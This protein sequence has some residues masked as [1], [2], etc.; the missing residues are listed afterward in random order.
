M[1]S[2]SPIAHNPNSVPTAG[3]GETDVHTSLGY[4]LQGEL[5][6]GKR[7]SVGSLVDVYRGV[8]IKPESGA[9]EVAIK[10]LRAFAPLG[11]E[12]PSDRRQALHQAALGLQHL[13]SRD[14][15]VV[16]GNICPENV[17]INDF[18]AAV[19]SDFDLSRA[20]EEKTG[21]TTT[22]AGG[23]A[24]RYL[25]P[26]AFTA[27]WPSS[28]TFPTDI[29]AF[30][31][32]I[33]TAMSGRPPHHHILGVGRYLLA[34]MQGAIPTPA[35]HPGLPGSDSLWNLM[36]T[37]WANGP[38]DRPSID[39]VVNFL[40]RE[41]SEDA[42]GQPSSPVTLRV[43]LLTVDSAVDEAGS[44]NDVAESDLQLVT[45]LPGELAPEKDP[46]LE[47]TRQGG[48]A[49]VVRGRWTRPDGVTVAVAI[50]YLRTVVMQKTRTPKERVLRVNKRVDR[51]A[52]V[53]RRLRSPYILEFYGFRSGDQPC[54]V[55]PWCNNGT[56]NEYLQAHP[57][58]T[59]VDKLNLL[60]QAGKGLQYLHH[61]LPPISHGDIKPSNI[62]IDDSNCPRLCDFGLSRFL[63]EINPEL[64]T[65]FL[66]QG[67]KGYQSPELVRDGVQDLPG[68]VYAFGCLILEVMSGHAPFYKLKPG[69]AIL[70]TTAGSTPEPS[71]H[72]S[73]PATDPLWNIM[74]TIIFSEGLGGDVYPIFS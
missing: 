9:V 37:C 68:D 34:V 74:R 73:L 17:L 16:H 42:Q 64:Q 5:T 39:K 55:S 14:P 72:P 4:E 27:D 58:L 59:A 57:E 49:D 21:F 40:G 32:V 20:I 19:L 67:T 70:V 2:A 29:Y 50:K 18:K 6:R 61:L 3:A 24:N 53:W 41:T 45:E 69:K 15:P 51:E 23:Q 71:A 8:W 38:T 43:P 12:G 10:V 44:L 22:G 25:A 30:G 46:S 33:L 47:K 7:H 66:G 11:D 48:F 28:A 63:G 56:L 54:L 65:S 35:D 52:L 1:A 31:G 62:L 36:S 60:V 13:H 26:E